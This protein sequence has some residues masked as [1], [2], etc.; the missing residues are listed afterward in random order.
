M[1]RQRTFRFNIILNFFILISSFQFSII[2][3]EF[4]ESTAKKND[5]TI[6]RPYSKVFLT[7]TKVEPLLFLKTVIINFVRKLKNFEKKVSVLQ[8]LDFS[9]KISCH[10]IPY[11]KI[12]LF[13]VF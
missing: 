7:K 5:F 3:R 12:Q 4:Y 6:L 11:R 9:K 10:W 8:Y 2:Y 1:F 13:A